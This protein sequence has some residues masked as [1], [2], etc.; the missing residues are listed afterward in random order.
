[1]ESAPDG[2]Q[3]ARVVSRHNQYTDSSIVF[4]AGGPVN[5]TSLSGA[6]QFEVYNNTFSRVNAN[7]DINKWIWARGDSGVIA[8]NVM[9]LA[10]SSQ[11][12]GKKQVR[13]GV[14][15]S[16]LPPWPLLHQIGQTTQ[17]LAENPPSHPL[18]LFGNTGAGATDPSFLSI[19]ANDTG[20]GGF[21]CSNPGTYIQSGRD[22]MTSNTWGWTPFTYPHPLN[23]GPSSGNGPAPP[24]GLAASVQ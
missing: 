17:L 11:F 7:N 3:G 5:D 19:E 2:D 12:G 10:S 21:T 15:C 24:Q 13:L 1:L 23:L 14:G 18:L 4:H 8:N 22:Y 20:G 16:G 6:R 9:D